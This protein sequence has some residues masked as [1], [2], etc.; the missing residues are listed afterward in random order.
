M[1][2]P[3]ATAESR[4]AVW[5]VPG[6][7]VIWA[8]HFTLC[9]V[10]ASLWCGRVG[11]NPASL[12]SA[13]IAIAIYTAIA[14]A[15]VAAIGWKGYR[16]HR[17]GVTAPHDADSPEDRYRFIGF[18]AFLIAALSTLAIIYS[19]LAAVFIRTCE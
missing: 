4:Q 12:S 17:A 18:A 5:I 2:H 11:G 15:L 6:P 16:A 14:L 7:L 9:Y 1:I 8:I 19:S 10:T 13:R 3:K